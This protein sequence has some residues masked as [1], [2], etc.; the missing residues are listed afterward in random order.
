M[1]T[2]FRESFWRDVKKIKDQKT[3]AHIDDVIAEA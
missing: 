1:K 2:L 3:I